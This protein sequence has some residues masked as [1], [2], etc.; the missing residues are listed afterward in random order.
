[1]G[2]MVLQMMQLEG[3]NLEKYCHSVPS[4]LFDSFLFIKIKIKYMEL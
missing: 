3:I 4:V 2:Y 1:M